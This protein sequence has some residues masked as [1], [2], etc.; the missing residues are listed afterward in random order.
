M[1]AFPLPRRSASGNAV[2]D[3]IGIFPGE[4][5]GPEVVAIALEILETLPAVT[6]RR[7]DLRYG[8]AIGRDSLRQSGKSLPD[9]AIVFASPCLTTAGR[10]F[11]GPAGQD[12]P[13]TDQQFSRSLPDH[14]FSWLP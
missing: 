7:F 4:G 1:D 2:S 5:I 11:A 8:G 10:S 6:G 12:L 9:E 13:V 3:T 14:S